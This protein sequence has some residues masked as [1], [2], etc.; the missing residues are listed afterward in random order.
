MPEIIRRV[1]G[2][3]TGADIDF[4]VE[5]LA[6]EDTPP[7]AGRPQE[8]INAQVDRADL[9]LGCLWKSLGSAAGDGD[10]T[11]FEEEF[12]RTINRQ[13]KE[14]SPEI[15]LLFKEVSVMVRHGLDDKLQK[16]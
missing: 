5:L 4:R 3:L 12:Y 15:W 8:L 13:A 6:W 16:V 2:I 9:F 1:N 14:G 10:K 11:G 7:G